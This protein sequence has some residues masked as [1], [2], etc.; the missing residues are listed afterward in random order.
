[1]TK[2]GMSGRSRRRTAP[3][4]RMSWKPRVTLAQVV[5]SLTISKHSRQSQVLVTA[6]IDSPKQGK[7]E[8]GFKA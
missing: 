3:Q 4:G 2:I 5:H 8:T 7:E 6:S 1:M